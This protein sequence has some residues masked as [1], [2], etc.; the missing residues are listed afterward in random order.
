MYN[1]VGCHQRNRASQRPLVHFT[2]FMA[3]LL[4]NR[5]VLFLS[6]QYIMTVCKWAVILGAK[7]A[8]KR[9]LLKQSESVIIHLAPLSRDGI[10]MKS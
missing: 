6:R 2:R 8:A 7:V 3:P 5:T 9:G 1:V 10:L 4:A